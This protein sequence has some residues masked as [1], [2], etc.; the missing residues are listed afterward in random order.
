[1]KI[2][3][4]GVC[5]GY[6][7]FSV[8]H[9]IDLAMEDGDFRLVVGPNGAGK[10]TMLRSI[11]GIVRPTAGQILVGGDDVTHASPSQLLDRGIAYVPQEPSIFPHLTVADNLE[12]GL[13]QT[14]V[15]GKAAEDSIRRVFERFENLAKRRDVPARTLSGGERRLLELARALM[16]K[17]RM[18]LLDE[19]SLGLS[20]IMMD[21][22]L[23]EIVAIN[24]EGVTVLLIEQRVKAVAHVA[25]SISILRLGRVTKNGT[26]EQAR[27]DSWLANA[28]YDEGGSPPDNSSVNK[29]GSS[30]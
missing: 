29:G 7:R 23:H 20:P 8:L 21:R 1:M 16:I 11:F 3:L 17:P 4:A 14:G 22:I 26:A 12:M 30:S 13:F 19:P 10:T 27:D 5:A 6:G 15:R 28:L 2:E 9:G 24:N 18:L 25:K